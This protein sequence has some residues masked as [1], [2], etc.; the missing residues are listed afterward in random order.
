MQYVVC[1]HHQ[2]PRLKLRFQ[3]QR[4]VY[5]HLVAVEI[6]VER[7]ANQRVQLNRLAFDQDRLERLDAEA[8]KRRGAIEQDW[9]FAN[10]LVENVPDFRL[11]LL[12]ELLRLLDRGRKTLGVE[13][14]IDERLEQFER[15]FLPQ[16][17][18]MQL[19][20]RA[21]H[22][23]G[24]A[25]IVDAL[26]QQ[27]LAEAALLAF[28]HVSE[29]L[30][31]PLVGAGNDATAAA[32]VEQRVDRLLQH[33]FLVADD[34]VGSAQ[35]DEPLQAIVAVNDAAIEIVEVGRGK[36]AAVKRSERAQVRL[37]LRQVGQD[38]PFRLVAGLD[39]GLNQ[40]EPLG[41]LLRLY[42]RG[43]FGDLLVQVGRPPRNVERLAR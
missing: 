18:L 39:E 34:D 43:R 28:E 40:L 7:R 4:H 9:M 24:T 15:Q 36:T 5:G 29:R 19:E 14:R 26:A 38:H 3:R 37:Y 25:R 6:G 16:P 20:F 11:L 23:D 2:H 42:L 32:V 35:L 31:R 22:D 8:M 10:N 27:I 12:D 21:D 30:Q 17:A 41:E 13:P 33:P 1:G